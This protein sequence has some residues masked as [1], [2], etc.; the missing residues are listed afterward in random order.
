MKNS[1][2]NF[3]E[4]L[5][6]KEVED[7]AINNGWATKFVEKSEAQKALI[8]E[9]FIVE[10]YEKSN[11]QVTINLQVA[12]FNGENVVAYMKA[13]NGREMFIYGD[14]INKAIEQAK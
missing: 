13:S 12:K 6:S 3:P 8:L 10:N 14:S 11:G 5:T 9:N 4:V 2:S 1:N 7:I